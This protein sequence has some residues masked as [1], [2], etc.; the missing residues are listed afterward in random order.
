VS[1]IISLKKG[2]GCELCHGISFK[3]K[4]KAQ[5]KPMEDEIFDLT[6]PHA[7]VDVSI[8]NIHIRYA[9]SRVKD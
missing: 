9:L 8:S 6:C 4:E 3:S 2:W 5:M 1:E 7:S